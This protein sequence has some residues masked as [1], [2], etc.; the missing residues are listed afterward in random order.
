NISELGGG[1]GE[2]T[3]NNCTLRSNYASYG[4]AT[5]ACTLN[6]C[7][8]VSNAAVNVGSAGAVAG[9]ADFGSTLRNCTVVGNSAPSRGGVYFSTVTNSIIYF[10]TAGSGANFDTDS[11]LSYCCTTPL[12]ASGSGNLSSDP[13][14]LD[15]PGGNLRL[16]SN[17]PCVN[18][19]NNAYAIGATDLDGH[20]RIFGGT[21]DIGAYEFQGS[22]AAVAPYIIS[23]PA[24]QTTTVEGSVS[25]TVF[26]GGS[27]PLSYQ[28]T[29]NSA[30]IGG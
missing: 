19:G 27:T 7:L 17:S 8:L 2:S 4:G 6:N 15:M 21:V 16:Q 26:A 24:S 18:A 22:S 25:F 11:G 14:F 9:G 13:L 29:F 1:A 3:L 10:N 5:V 20:P 23:Q 12:P 28:W 30:N